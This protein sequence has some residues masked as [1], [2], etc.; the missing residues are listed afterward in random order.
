MYAQSKEEHMITFSA[1]ELVSDAGVSLF[2]GG[3]VE[4]FTSSLGPV[5]S[6]TAAMG[7]GLEMFTSSLAP[8]VTHIASGDV[9]GAFTSSLIAQDSS[10]SAGEAT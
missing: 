1:T 7:E 4:A 2:D 10:V 8:S 6:A 9:T 3:A 5:M